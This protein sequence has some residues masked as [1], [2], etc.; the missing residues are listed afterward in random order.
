MRSDATKRNNLPGFTLVELLVVL[1]IIA[2]LIGLIAP[3]VQN[4]RASAARISCANNLRQVGLALHNFHDTHQHLP[5]GSFQPISQLPGVRPVTWMV[6]ILPQID[7]TALWQVAVQACSSGSPPYANP[8][9]TGYSTVLRFYSCPADGRLSSPMVDSNSGD[10]AAYTSYIGIAGSYIGSRLIGNISYSAPGALGDD[11]GINLIRITDGT[12]MTIMVGERPPPDSLQ[13]GRW[14]T[15]LSGSVI[16]G[17]GPDEYIILPSLV[18]PSE[19]EC[20]LS[21]I[22]FGPGR[23][24]NPCDRHHL[25]SLHSGGANFLHADGAVHFLQYSANSIIPALATRSGGEVVVL[26]D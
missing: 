15:T 23:I 4:S 26:P 10:I 11:P 9:H 24:D 25:W 20:M 2:L 17:N 21:G 8:P 6:D 12:S 18:S 13:A 19:T 7:Q 22:S 1:G 5:P 14:Y 3:A 16:P